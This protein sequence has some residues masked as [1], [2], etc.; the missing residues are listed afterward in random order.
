MQY[1]NVAMLT[2][3]RVELPQMSKLDKQATDAAEAAFGASGAGAYRKH[4]Y[5]K[6]IVD[7]IHA[8]VASA[9]AYLASQTRA[10]GRTEERMVPNRRIPAYL[11][12]MGRHELAFW[13]NVTVFLNNYAQVLLAAQ[14]QQGGLF[15]A[16]EYPDV[17]VLRGQFVFHYPLMPIGMVHDGLMSELD[18]AASSTIIAKARDDERAANAAVVADAVTD[19]RREVERI[20]KQ[21]TVIP[22]MNKKGEYAEKSG[23]IYD[24]LT[25]DIA[26]LVGVLQDLN[27]GGNEQLMEVIADVDTHLTIPA[28]A[29]RADVEVCRITKAKAEEILKAMEAFT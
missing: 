8:C 23:K 16:G 22:Y 26:Q 1:H 2:R 21:T 18:E 6:H 15:D 3:L 4:L 12:G 14:Q 28:D 13:Q 17:A 9:R 19:L 29:L 5:P 20:I 24:S 7:P 10:Y 25:N 11:D 27:A